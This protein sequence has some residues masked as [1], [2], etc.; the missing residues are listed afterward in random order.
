MAAHDFVALISWA[1]IEAALFRFRK[2]PF[3][4]A[5]LPGKRNP[6]LTFFAFVVA[7]FLFASLAAHIE[8]RLFEKPTLVLVVI[9]ILA[10]GWMSYRR[11]QRFQ[12][13][14]NRDLMFEERREPAVQTLSL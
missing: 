10:L 14:P 2:I 5:H 12:E 11:F 1:F 8:H 4:C 9:G 3:T 6:G 13:P 7:F